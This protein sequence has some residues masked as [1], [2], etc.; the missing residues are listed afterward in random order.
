MAILIGA[1]SRILV[2]GLGKDGSFQA[3]RM[4]SYGSNVVA[5]V[6]PGRG[7]GK[8]DSN[9]PYFNA[10]TDAVLKTRANVGIIFVPAP[11][12][13]DTIIEQADAGIELI[14]CITEGIPIHD[15][16]KVRAYLGSTNSML[17]GPNCPG[18]ITPSTHTKVGI[19]PHEIVKAGNVGVVSRSGTLTYE[20]ISQLASKGIGQTTCVGIGGDS[21][22]GL[23]FVD[24]LRMFQNDPDTDAIVLIGEIGGQEEQRAAEYIKSSVT[25]PVVAFIAGRTAPKGKRMGH[26]GAVI[27]GKDGLASSKEDAL[28]KAGAVIADKPNLIADTLI[29]E[30]S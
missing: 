7:G 21:I 16:A 15:M 12:A 27:V 4:L 5:A 2:Q 9:I 19:I 26:A 29:Q 3:R 22:K 13:P 24:I 1:Q 28:R 6:H 10:V 17:L 30:M 11:Y 14:V 8:F 25:K 18:A 20:A 23:Q